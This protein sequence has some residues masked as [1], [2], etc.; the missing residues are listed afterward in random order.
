[1]GQSARPAV[2][3]C[4]AVGIQG[5][6]SLAAPNFFFVQSPTHSLFSPQH[7]EGKPR[8]AR[9]FAKYGVA[10]DARPGRFERSEPD[11]TYGVAVTVS[12]AN[13]DRKLARTISWDR[14]LARTIRTTRGDTMRTLRDVAKQH[15]EQR[16]D[17]VTKALLRAIGDPAF[18]Y[19]VTNEIERA[20]VVKCELARRG[21]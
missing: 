17:S 14:K 19:D 3:P 12:R 20:L 16:W 5:P 11:W 1:V 2:L 4:W 15:P 13:W 21:R 7:T 9:G 18:I 10:L 6:G 8:T